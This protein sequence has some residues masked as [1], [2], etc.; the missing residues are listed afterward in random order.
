MIN[1]KKI[2]YLIFKNLDNKKLVYYPVAK[3]ANSSAKLFFAKHLGLDK[4]LYFIEDD[5]PRFKQN[6]IDLKKYEGKINLINFMP[7]YNKFAKVDVEEKCCLIRNPFERFISTYKNR[8]LYHK[9]P[10]FYGN[11]INEILEKLENNIIEN[12]H[13]LPQNYWLGNDLGYFT[14]CVNI[15]NIK[16]FEKKINNFFNK[17]ISFPKVQTGGNNN[18]IVL[19]ISQKNKI[20]KVYEKDFDLLGSLI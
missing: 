8:I 10:G 12:K 2:D 17:K 11:S 9:D 15:K 19:N 7:A 20:K 16:I 4:K 6:K 14:I 13:F 18:S 5:I 3:N 1:R